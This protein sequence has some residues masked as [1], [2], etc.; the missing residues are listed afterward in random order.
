MARRLRI[1]YAGAMH[2]VINRG[3]Y[4]RD[5]FESVGAAEAFLRIL[6]KYLQLGES[7]TLRGYLHQSKRGKNQQN[8]A[9]PLRITLLQEAVWH[10][11]REISIHE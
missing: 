1:E 8:T 9:S 4:R 2:P 11:T 3:N 5:L 10:P 7:A 6:A